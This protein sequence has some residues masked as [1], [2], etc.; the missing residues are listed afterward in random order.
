MQ[1]LMPDGHFCVAFT[2]LEETTIAVIL[3][4]RLYLYE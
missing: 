2:M 4:L 1:E 3:K